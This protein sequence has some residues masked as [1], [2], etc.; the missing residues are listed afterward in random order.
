MGGGNCLLITEQG[1]ILDV[2]ECVA[3]LESHNGH[4]QISQY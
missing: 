2:G 3:V 1:V 4:L